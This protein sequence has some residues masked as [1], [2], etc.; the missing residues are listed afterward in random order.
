MRLSSL[1]DYAIVMMCAAARHG[2]VRLSAATLSGETRVPLATAQKLMQRL[3]SAG[4][5]QSQRGA[6][7]GF[8]LTRAPSAIS[9][10]DIIEAIEGPI[11]LTTCV[12]LERHECALDGHCQTKPHWGA[13]N[14]AVRGA[15]AGVSLAQLSA[16][17]VARAPELE[18]Q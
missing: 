4:L 14:A 18:T 9:L 3:A 10:A 16:P 1:A 12:D 11:G 8:R 5:L 13:V 17:V 2:D 15:L 6:V 7:G